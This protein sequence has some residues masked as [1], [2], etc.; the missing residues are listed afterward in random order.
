MKKMWDYIGVQLN[1]K[2]LSENGWT[3][4][5]IA[6]INEMVHSRRNLNIRPLTLAS[7]A[8]DP[9]FHASG[10]DD[11][12]WEIAASFILNFSVNAGLHRTT[13]LS[14]LTYYRAK[15]GIPFGMSLT[16]IH[17]HVCN[18]RLIDGLHMPKKLSCVKLHRS[19]CHFMPQLRLSNGAINHMHCRKQTR[20]IACYLNVRPNWLRFHRI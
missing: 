9:R 6:S 7:Y 12:E 2:S 3:N 18:L 20:E 11:A 16:Y 1:E 10:L 13:V 19:C 17:L 4:D 8:L 14:E 5:E 15:S